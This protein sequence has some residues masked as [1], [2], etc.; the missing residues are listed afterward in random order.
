MKRLRL[1]RELLNFANNA[2]NPLFSG[3]E[4]LRLIMENM[5]ALK[6]I[7]PSGTNHKTAD[8]LKTREDS[9]ILGSI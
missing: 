8:T 6:L 2:L 9:G 1:E 4:V 5:Q 7:F 3:S